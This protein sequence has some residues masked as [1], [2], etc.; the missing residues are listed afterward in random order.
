MSILGAMA[1]VIAAVSLTIILGAMVA[2]DGL[3]GVGN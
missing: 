1:G 2:E 3:T